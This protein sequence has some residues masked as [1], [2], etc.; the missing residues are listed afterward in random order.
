MKIQH[1]I[2]DIPHGIFSI[3]WRKTSATYVI[4]HNKKIFESG[5]DTQQ[6]AINYL[7]HQFGDNI[8][9]QIKQNEI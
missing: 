5:F 6:Q 2:K 7:I 1:I 8:L 3:R 9:K 4:Y